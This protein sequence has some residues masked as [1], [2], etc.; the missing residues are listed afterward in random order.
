MKRLSLCVVALLAVA[1]L[2]FTGSAQEKIALFICNMAHPFFVDMVEGA[3]DA[4]EALGAKVVPFDGQNDPATQLAQVED[5]IAAGYDA[6]LLNPTSLEA[7]VP[8]V[9]KANEAGIPVFTLD[10]DVAGGERIAYIGTANVDAAEAGARYLLSKLLLLGRPLPWRI[11]H[12]WGTPGSSAA[13]ERSTGVHNVLDPFVEA[14]VVEIVADLTAYFD[15]AKGLHVMED[16]L[17]TTVDIDAVITGNDEMA[18]GALEALKGVGLKVGE[19]DGV[20]IMGFDAIP[21]ALDAVKRGDFIGTVAQAPYIMGYWGVEAAV[22]H[23]REGWLP[24]KGTPVYEPTGALHLD[25]GGYIV[26]AENVDSIAA[27]VKTPPPLP[28]TE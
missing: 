12:L 3:Q 27:L 16:I 10:R 5:A 2:V 15:R 28:G 14:G 19:P 4:A 7:M 11:V 26:T 6:I 23:L 24:P 25:T 22:R 17:A 18:L 1:G 20:L 21:D 8:A 9:A 13:I